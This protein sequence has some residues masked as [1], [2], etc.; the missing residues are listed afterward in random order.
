[1]L[2]KQADQQGRTL[3]SCVLEK[4][5]REMNPDVELSQMVTVLTIHS[6][7]LPIPRLNNNIGKL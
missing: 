6:E 5:P 1:M 2:Q 3:N 7:G 4:D